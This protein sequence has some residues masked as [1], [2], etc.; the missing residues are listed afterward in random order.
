MVG[1]GSKDLFSDV[2]ALNRT[3]GDTSKTVELFKHLYYTQRSLANDCWPIAKETLFAA[4]EFKFLHNYIRDPLDEFYIIKD[5]YID[6]LTFIKKQRDS[7]LVNIFNEEFVERC[8]LLIQFTLAIYDK[9]TAI[10]IQRKALK[11]LDDYRFRVAI[12]TKCNQRTTL[13]APNSGFGAMA[14]DE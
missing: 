12:Q 10:E 8:V 4:K 5:D 7:K 1:H 2:Q 9:Q 6:N 14:A 11:T 3:L 13:N